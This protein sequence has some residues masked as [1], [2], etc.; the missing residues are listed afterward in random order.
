VAHDAGESKQ[1]GRGIAAGRHELIL[2]GID[3]GGND[4][5]SRYQW[6]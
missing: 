4:E 2:A 1:S 6:N 5:D 3:D